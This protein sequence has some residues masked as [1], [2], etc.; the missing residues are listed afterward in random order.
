MLGKKTNSLQPGIVWMPYIPLQKVEIINEKDFTPRVSLKSRYSMKIVNSG[1][2]GTFGN[3]GF[4]MSPNQLRKHK[5]EN[6]FKMKNP[7]D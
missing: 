5:I 1:M 3:G 6:I 7:T 2:Y 4:Y